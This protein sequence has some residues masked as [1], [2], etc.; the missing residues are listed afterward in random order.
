MPVVRKHGWQ[1]LIVKRPLRFSP[2]AWDE[3]PEDAEVLC[4]A[5][6]NLGRGAAVSW[7]RGFNEAELA[8]P[9]GVWAVVRP[10]EPVSPVEAPPAT[11]GENSCHGTTL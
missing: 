4:T 5:F 8:N 2:A 7:C 10:Y 6:S 11:N 3:K 9:Y 1:V